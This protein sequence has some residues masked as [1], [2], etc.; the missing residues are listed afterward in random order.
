MISAPAHGLICLTLVLPSVAGYTPVDIQLD[1][2]KNLM[3]E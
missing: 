1:E 2:V 3:K